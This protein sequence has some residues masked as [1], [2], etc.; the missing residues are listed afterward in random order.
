MM[1]VAFPD[2]RFELED[3]IAEGDKAV[4]R[5]SVRGTH[6][7]EMMGLAPTGKRVMTTVHPSC[8]RCH[9]STRCS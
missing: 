1:D 5:V 6:R 4:A 7:G 2:F 8:G 9:P 3:V